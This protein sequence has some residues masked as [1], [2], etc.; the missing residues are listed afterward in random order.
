[1]NELIIN[2][3]D[4]LPEIFLATNQF[5]NEVNENLNVAFEQYKENGTQ[6]FY[7]NFNNFL[8]NGWKFLKSGI[9]DLCVGLKTFGDK[10]A[11]LGGESFRQLGTTTN[12]IVAKTG[13]FFNYVDNLTIQVNE[14]MQQESNQEKIEE[15]SNTFKTYIEFLANALNDCSKST[16]HLYGD[17]IEVLGDNFDRL[18]EGLLR[19]IQNVKLKCI[20]GINLSF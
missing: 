10:M 7:T 13:D 19:F 14:L 15:I 16:L 20:I 3:N 6:A 2:L 9:G 8:N 5:L 1:M 11:S 4:V 12:N 18:S 17:S